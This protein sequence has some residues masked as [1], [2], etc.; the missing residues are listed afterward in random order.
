MAQKIS[1]LR[2]KGTENF[3]KTISKI[4]VNLSR[5]SFFP[6]IFRSFDISSQHDSSPVSLA[7]AVSVAST[8]GKDGGVAKPSMFPF[9]SSRQTIWHF[10]DISGNFAPSLG[11]SN[12][13]LNDFTILMH[14]L[15][16]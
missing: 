15:R 6:E 8:K 1:G 4:L 2:S 12:T 7:L 3:R 14:T 10:F 11:K 9:F 16:E 13:E 5:L